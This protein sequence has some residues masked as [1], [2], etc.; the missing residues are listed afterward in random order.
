MHCPANAGRPHFDIADIVRQHRAELEAAVHLSVQQRRVLTAMTLC[1][2]ADLGG[3]VDVCRSCGYEHPSYNSCRNRHCPKC[4]ALAQERWIRAR[5]E[6]LLPVKHFH[7]V[8][9]LPSELRRLAKLRSREVFDALLTAAASTLADLAQTRLEA[10]LGVTA[11]LHTWTRDLQF[12]PHVHTIV[13]A[14]GLSRQHDGWLASN[15]KYLFPVRVM[16]ALLRGKMLAELAELHR[17][18]VFAGIADF[19]DPAAFPRLIARLARSRWIVYAKKPFG[20]AEH[21]LRYLGRYTHRVAISSGR[22]T[23]ASKAEITFRTKGGNTVTLAPVEFLRRFVQHV[24]PGGFHK[25]RHYGLY[26]SALVDNALVAA[27]T[28]LAALGATNTATPDPWP[29]S[30]AEQLETLTARDVTRCPQCGLVLLR[31]PVA[32]PNSRAPPLTVAA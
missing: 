6:R 17:R 27:R 7:V 13:T 8:F 10:R 32:K 18:G 25:I 28:A 30:W 15:H 22:I 19:D 16:G 3:H 20:R 5:S 29:T 2:T 23:H 21:V 31:L 11:V 14:G 1:R 26:A 12:H 9:T 4:Q 24:L